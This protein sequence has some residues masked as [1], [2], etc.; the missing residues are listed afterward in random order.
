MVVA[1]TKRLLLAVIGLVLCLHAVDAGF[2]ASEQ[3]SGLLRESRSPAI[4]A[5]HEATVAMP[6]VPGSRERRAGPFDAMVVLC[7]VLVVALATRTAEP[8]SRARRHTDG[9]Y[10]R[11]RGPPLQF[12]TV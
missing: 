6:A 12:V 4:I 7:G 5:P 10:V 8:G 9:F 1:M 11:R 2:G 3:P